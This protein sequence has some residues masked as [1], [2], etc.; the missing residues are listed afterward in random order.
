MQETNSKNDWWID[1]VA[2]CIKKRNMVIQLRF[3]FR[4]STQHMSMVQKFLLL[5]QV[6]NN[7]TWLQFIVDF[8]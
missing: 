2:V 7:F 1:D 3:L 5:I 8:S 6:D 4:Y